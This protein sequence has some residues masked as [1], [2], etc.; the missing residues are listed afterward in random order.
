MEKE[1]EVRMTRMAL[2]GACWGLLPLLAPASFALVPSARDK[3]A[4]A[5][6][7]LEEFVRPG[8]DPEA[9]SR[10][11]RPTKADYAAVWSATLAPKLLAAYEPAWEQ[12]VLVV[13]GKP[14]QRAV[15]AWGAGSEEL[16]SWT[17][18]AAAH[19]PGGWKDVA[20]HLKPGVRV[21]A[22]KFVEPGQTTGMAFD[23]LVHVNGQWRIFPKPWRA[24]R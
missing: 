15:L 22:F 18:A 2:A 12:G 21:Y 14:A 8:A 3:D 17:G 13:R 19:F 4:E 24:L 9:L 23:G 11:L 1:A 5:V 16:K 10:R 6:A 7:V 20:L